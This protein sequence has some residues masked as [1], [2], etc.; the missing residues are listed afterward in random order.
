MQLFSKINSI[1]IKFDPPA[2]LNGAIILQYNIYVNDG[3]GSSIQYLAN[4][5]DYSVLE[6][7]TALDGFLNTLVSGKEYEVGVSA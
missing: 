3:D 4:F 2:S 6:F 5:V 7:E 1:Q